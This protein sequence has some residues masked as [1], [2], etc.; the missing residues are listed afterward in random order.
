MGRIGQKIAKIAKSIT[1]FLV[2]ALG[3]FI[4]IIR[5]KLKDDI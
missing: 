1:I 3:Y 5:A 4:I 2:F